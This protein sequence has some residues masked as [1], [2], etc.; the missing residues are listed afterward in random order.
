[1]TKINLTAIFEHVLGTSEIS[2]KE[3][4]RKV[5]DALRVMENKPLF[6]EEELSAIM[7]KAQGT[8]EALAR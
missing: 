1:M 8:D 5:I 4:L 3:D 2:S 7:E 6:T